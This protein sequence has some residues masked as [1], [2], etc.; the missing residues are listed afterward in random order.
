ML[1]SAI[2]GREFGTAELLEDIHCV[3]C[4][5]QLVIALVDVVSLPRVVGP[6]K[7]Q[8]LRYSLAFELLY[9]QT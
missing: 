7:H 6:R 1:G 5:P 4:G 3:R 2:I 9:N 8:R